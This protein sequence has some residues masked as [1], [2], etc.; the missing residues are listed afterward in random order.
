[1]EPRKERLATQE[2]F[3]DYVGI[4]PAAAAQ[5]RYTG[6][7]PAF[8]KVTGRQVRYRWED[9][10]RWVEERTRIRTDMPRRPASV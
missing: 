10:E 7:G 2:E 6:N 1:M 8:I 4:T 5:L 3:C 9:I